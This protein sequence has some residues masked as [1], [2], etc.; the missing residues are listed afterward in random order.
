MTDK[1]YHGSPKNL[2]KY[3]KPNGYSR[4]IEENG[5]YLTDSIE[6][7][8]TYAMNYRWDKFASINVYNFEKQQWDFFYILRSKKTS[9]GYI[10]ETS[11]PDAVLVDCLD[12]ET[13]INVP[14]EKHQLP[15]VAGAFVSQKDC[16]ISAKHGVNYNFLKDKF[17]HIKVFALKDRKH[18]QKAIKKI[19]QLAAQ[20]QTKDRAEY[21]K[22]MKA[23]NKLLDK[24]TE[25]Q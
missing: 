19:E 18:F 16:S 10:Y 12:M 9:L 17:T 3:L 21:D 8:A 23:L 2:K 20:T 25:K 6:L 13:C 11:T 5:L 22:K 1:L 15:N 14:I 24:Y 4:H 7:A